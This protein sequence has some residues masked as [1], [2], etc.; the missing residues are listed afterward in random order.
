[1]K[2][3]ATGKILII[4][5]EPGILR[6]L[7]FA[8][9]RKGYM[10]DTA[11]T[12]PEGIQKFLSHTYDLVL[13]DIKMPGMTGDAVLHELKKIKDNTVPVVGM[14]GTPWLLHD[15]LFDDVLEKPCSIKKVFEVI[16][17]LLP[18]PLVH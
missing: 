10:S 5:D 18:P 16:E 17:N 14:S 12:G 1:M 13:T 8:L 4:D 11:Q 3:T 9:S 2:K 7:A 15:H 6:M